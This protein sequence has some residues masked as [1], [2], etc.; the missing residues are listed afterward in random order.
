MEITARDLAILETVGELG[1]ADTKILHAMYFPAD[2]TGAAC[3]QRLRKL[4]GEG[5]LKRV[6]LTAVDS[7]N[8]GGSL[9]LLY[10]VTEEGADVVESE[11]GCRPRR[12][13][14]SDP[15]PLT[16]RHRMDTVRARLAIDCAAKLVGLAPPEWIMEQDMRESGK[17]AKGRSPSEFQVL[18][19]RYPHDG[20]TVSFR[21]DAGFH[22]QTP[23]KGR[24]ASLMVYLETDR[25]TE[26]HGQFEDKLPAIAA[27]LDDGGKGW[28]GHWP[29]V[30]D[31]T[32]FVCVLC[33]SPERVGNLGKTIQASP[34]A[35][36]I[37][38]TTYPLDPAKVL[39]EYVWQD[40]HG[41]RK[42]IIKPPE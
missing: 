18:N 13:T 38:L 29:H 11:T 24:L 31:P 28:R 22:L 23:Y 34:A 1:S 39:T 9:P 15:K 36:F 14:R 10:F 7:E 40:S 21:P 16:L 6:R 4:A 3:Q 26:G 41:E 8:P 33:K 5:L 35:R 25:S 30:T 27:F 19:N 20:R 12:I 17:A 32:I 2:N 37:R 42:R